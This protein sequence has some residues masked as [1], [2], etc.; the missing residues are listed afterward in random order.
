[1]RRLLVVLVAALALAGLAGVT[2]AQA[3]S[4]SKQV[5][6]K[7]DHSQDVLRFFDTRAWM[8]ATRQEKCWEVPWSRT[9]SIA[10]KA[11]A[12][13]SRRIVRLNERLEY[14]EVR[15]LYSMSPSQ[16]ICHVFGGYCSQAL[17][18]ASCESGWR[19][20]AVNG[21]YL[22]MFQMGSSERATYGHGSTPYEQAL[23]AYRYFARTGHTW[24]PW[25]CKP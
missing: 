4:E 8:R 3:V 13:H 14:L 25:S 22:G 12:W 16:A 23:A 17:R 20:T 7:L 15:S 10:R 18:V 1:M 24:G 5:A 11:Y 2:G 9:C 6:S 19:T 21:Q